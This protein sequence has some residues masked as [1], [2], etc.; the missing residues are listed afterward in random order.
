M[1]TTVHR[2]RLIHQGHRVEL[3]E[4]HT[5]LWGGFGPT[6]VGFGYRRAVRVAVDG[7]AV[8]IRDHVMIGRVAMVAVVVLAGAWRR[9]KP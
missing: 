1:A 4:L 7:V 2:T 9:F 8:P 3:T 6:G 5:S